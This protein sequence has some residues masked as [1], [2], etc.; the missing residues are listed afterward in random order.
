MWRLRAAPVVQ[1]SYLCAACAPRCGKK[2][3]YLMPISENR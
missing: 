3:K 1:H 2:R